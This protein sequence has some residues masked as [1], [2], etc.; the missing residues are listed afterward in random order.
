MSYCLLFP[1]NIFKVIFVSQDK[2]H[3]LKA[4]WNSISKYFEC[5]FLLSFGSWSWC[6][7]SFC[8]L[9]I[10]DSVLVISSE[11]YCRKNL[12]EYFTQG[13]FEFVFP[14][15]LRE[16]PAQVHLKTNSRFEIHWEIYVFWTL[17][18]F[19]ARICPSPVHSHL[20]C[21]ALDVPQLLGPVRF[22]IPCHCW[23]LIS[24]L[25]ALWSHL[26][27]SWSFNFAFNSFREQ[28]IWKSCKSSTHFLVPF[29]VIIFLFFCVVFFSLLFLSFFLL[30]SPMCPGNSL[31]FCKLFD[32]VNTISSVFAEYLLLFAIRVFIK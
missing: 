19:F 31:L 17:Q 27:E 12:N 25:L 6:L 29:L 1:V 3:I 13:E 26:K 9:V 5:K 7:L 2:I 8:Y 11:N 20:D 4:T 16:V 15:L 28:W 32:P 18:Q 21:I 30:P 14:G 10:F 24:V 23:A 22:S